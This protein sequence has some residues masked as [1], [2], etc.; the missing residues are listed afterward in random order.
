VIELEIKLADLILVRGN[1]GLSYEIEW[2]T[3]SLYS[4]VAGLV[5]PNELIEAQSFRKTE[6]QALDYYQGY[7]F[8]C[9][10]ATDEQRR[11]SILLRKIGSY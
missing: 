8:T 6:Y 2:I 1:E 3:R 7:V 10:W 11:S 4:H 5:K 9:D